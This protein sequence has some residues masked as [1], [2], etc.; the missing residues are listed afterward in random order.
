MGDERAETYLRLRAETYLRVLVRP[1]LRP[2][3]I[4][5]SELWQVTRAGLIL[6]AAGLLD[7]EFLDDLTADIATALTVRSRTLLT[8]PGPARRRLPSR[9]RAPAPPGG[10]AGPLQLTP[11][12]QTLSVRS[13]RAPF[14]RA[15][16][17]LHLLTLVR[18]RS[19]TAIITAI[20][21]YWPEDG[22]SADLEITGA[23]V[24][25]F[26]YDEIGAT[27][28]RGAQYRLEFDG[29]SL[30]TTWQGVLRLLPPMPPG[31]RWLDL[32]AGSRGG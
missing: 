14:D 5:S 16:F 30:T 23:G 6:V 18:A 4:N 22:S 26:P 7:D 15:P 9:Y 19:E 10:A 12:W 25:H 13:D 21:M 29:D 1:P 28:D 11:V 32:I 20:R 2:E 24:Q 31:T 17:D 8:R 27:D 3:D